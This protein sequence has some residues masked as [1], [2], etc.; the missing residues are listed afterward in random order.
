[1][2]RRDLRD[3]GGAQR[4]YMLERLNDGAR[5]T[6]GGDQ[7][8]G[9]CVPEVDHALAQHHAPRRPIGQVDVF[10]RRLRRQAESVPG[11]SS[12]S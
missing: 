4:T 1:M 9:G 12:I 3:V 8:L 10:R 5:R 6:A 11:P 2:M 7:V